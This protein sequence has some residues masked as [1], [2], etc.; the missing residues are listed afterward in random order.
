MDEPYVTYVYV[1]LYVKLDKNC[2]R[3]EHTYVFH[4]K[5]A[6]KYVD[7][8]IIFIPAFL[9]RSSAILS[10]ACLCLND[11]IRCICIYNKKRDIHNIKNRNNNASV[12]QQDMHVCVV[13]KWFAFHLY[14]LLTL[15]QRKYTSNVILF[16]MFSIVICICFIRIG[17]DDCVS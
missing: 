11:R 17:L 12:H 15:K 5:K 3:T 6:K 16:Y 14:M 8:L 4:M 10:H 13:S 2:I 1:C 7:N 9:W